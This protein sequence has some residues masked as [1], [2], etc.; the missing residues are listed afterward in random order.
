MCIRIV[1]F[2]LGS[3]EKAAMQGVI[4]LCDVEPIP[5]GM[6]K[7]LKENCT[8]M[9]SARK[10]FWS[11][12]RVSVQVY[13]F[14][15]TLLRFTSILNVDTFQPTSTGILNHSGVVDQQRVSKATKS[16][17]LTEKKSSRF[18]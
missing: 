7:V 16:N 9:L 3:T 2:Q 8:A 15:I 18:R 10:T 5:A 11:P 1:A 14:V 13:P 4:I 17:A 12:P 6:V